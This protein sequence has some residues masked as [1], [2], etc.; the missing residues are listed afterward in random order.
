MKMAVLVEEGRRRLQNYS[1]RLAW[2]VRVKAMEKWTHKLR[3]SGYSATIRHQVIKT[4]IDKWE[5]MCREEDQGTRPI[6]RSRHWKARERQKEK[7]LKVTN[8]HKTQRNQTSAP[9]IIDPTSGSMTSE[10]KEVCRKFEVVTG[11][12]VVVQERAGDSI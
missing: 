6:H 1:R 9:L 12:R 3:R 2:E 5:K 11:M 4:A 10:I 7:D 8:W